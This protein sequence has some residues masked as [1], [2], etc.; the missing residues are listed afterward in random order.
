MAV[1][2]FYRMF[3]PR[4]LRRS[5]SFAGR[6]HRAYSKHS[7][8]ADASCGWVAFIGATSGSVLA[9]LPADAA[10]EIFRDPMTLISGV[11]APSGNAAICDGGFR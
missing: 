3:V 11:F 9:R 2:G 1:A 5:R 10:R 4:G 6:R 8:S 7:R